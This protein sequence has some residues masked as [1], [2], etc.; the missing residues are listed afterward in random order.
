MAR[1]YKYMR[2]PPIDD[3]PPEKEPEPIQK[4]PPEA[5]RPPVK[6][7]ST[8][9]GEGNGGNGSSESGGLEEIPITGDS[10]VL[11]GLAALVLCT[12]ALSKK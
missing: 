10:M 11:L 2:A 12:Y 4:P 6:D 7:A 1:D 9:T 3:K 8:D 5:E